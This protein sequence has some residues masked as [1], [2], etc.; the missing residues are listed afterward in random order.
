MNQLDIFDIAPPQTG[1]F[2][3]FI[4]IGDKVQGTFIDLREGPDGYDNEQVIYVLK[5]ADEKIWNVGIKKTNVV[6]LAQMSTAT[7][8]R[9]VGFRFDS[10][11]PAKK[12]GMNDTKIINAFHDKNVLDNE[13]LEKRAVIADQH[14]GVASSIG[15]TPPIPT[16]MPSA[17]TP[18]PVEAPSTASDLQAAVP[19]APTQTETPESSPMIETVRGLAVSVGLTTMDLDEAGQDAMIKAYTTMEYNDENFPLIINKL[20][21]FSK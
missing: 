2:K 13:W 6:V 20:T 3:K 4:N 7:L 11:K 1:E 10:I 14:G 12:Q 17:P 5:D 8:G 21:G 19:V 15:A 9:I 18:I 16:P